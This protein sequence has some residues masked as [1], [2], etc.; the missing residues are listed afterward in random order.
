MPVC[1]GHQLVDRSPR[2]T[3]HEDTAQEY[4]SADIRRTEL[5]AAVTIQLVAL[6]GLGRHG[7]V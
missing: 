2:T 1:K 3:A 5:V 6:F 4:G 7:A